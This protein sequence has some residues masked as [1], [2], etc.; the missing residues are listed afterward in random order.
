MGMDCE[1]CGSSGKVF[2]TQIDGTTMYACERCAG[3]NKKDSAQ[4]TLARPFSTQRNSFAEKDFEEPEFVAG[5]GKKIRQAREQK[6]LTIQELALELRERES[7]IQK[8]E[9]EKTLPN[10]DLAKKIEKFFGF[11]LTE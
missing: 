4:K 6:K 3:A 11:R 7:V 8:L 10:K 5:F 2:E 9:S 1:I